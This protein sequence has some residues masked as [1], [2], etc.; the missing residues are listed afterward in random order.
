MRL[1]GAPLWL[2]APR[3]DGLSFVSSAGVEGSFR[4]RHCMCTEG[5]RRLLSVHRKGF[6]A[7]VVPYG[8]R[9]SLGALWLTLLP[10]GHMPG[11]AQLLV[12]TE[13]YTT[14]YANHLG[15]ESVGLAEEFV[16]GHAECLVLRTSMAPV[17]PRGQALAQVVDRAQASLAAG[18]TP[19][20]LCRP[21]GQAQE[22]IRSLTSAG[23]E[24]ACHRLVAA[25]N[26]AYRQLGFDCGPAKVFRG[27]RSDGLALVLP[28]RQGVLP[29]VRSV[30]GARVFWLSCHAGDKEALRRLCADEGI[31]YG[32]HPDQASLLQFVKKTRARRVVLI[33]PYPEALVT[34]LERQRLE[35][36]VLGRETQLPLL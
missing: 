5:T 25:F 4:H 6:E 10:A 2:D 17:L 23:V 27:R 14:L 22:V 9:I 32:G 13:E 16:L 24:V 21:V 8:R 36:V 1:V 7:L 26:E 28:D 30:E 18:H 20:F 11:S 15:L 12:E 33:A 29:L 34:E 19:V 3:R 31:L 35:V